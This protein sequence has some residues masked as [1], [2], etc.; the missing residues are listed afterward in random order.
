[1]DVGGSLRV[2]AQT[3]VA[4][5][6]LC[7]HARYSKRTIGV[8]AEPWVLHG[9]CGGVTSAPGNKPKITVLEGKVRVAGGLVQLIPRLRLN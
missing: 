7:T 5:G 9:L 3:R 6:V 8:H 4:P 1:M 2:F